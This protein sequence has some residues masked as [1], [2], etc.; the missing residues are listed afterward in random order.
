VT[1]AREQAE[2]DARLKAE[3]DRLDHEIRLVELGKTDKL[4]QVTPRE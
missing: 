3:Q 4:S 2:R 1:V